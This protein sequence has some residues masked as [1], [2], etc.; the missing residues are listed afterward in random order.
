[1]QQRKM[2]HVSNRTMCAKK[3]TEGINQNKKEFWNSWKGKNKNEHTQEDCGKRRT[4]PPSPG[5]GRGE[6]FA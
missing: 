6:V 3:M 4:L 5:L 1:M 2:K